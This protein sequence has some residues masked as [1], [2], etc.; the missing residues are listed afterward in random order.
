LAEKDT[1]LSSIAALQLASNGNTRF[2]SSMSPR[3]SLPNKA[4]VTSR[5]RLSDQTRFERRNSAN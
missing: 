3:L 5:C 1:A 2:S 4:L